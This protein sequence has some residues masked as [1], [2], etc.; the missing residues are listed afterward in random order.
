M[1]IT[2]IFG[3]VAV[4]WIAIGLALSLLMGR[5]GHQSCQWFVIGAVLGPLAFA[6]AISALRH[7]TGER[8]RL[9][10]PGVP[11]SGTTDIVVGVDGSA[12]ARA[13]VRGVIQLF[14]EAMGRLTLVTVIPYDATNATQRDAENILVQQGKDAA[15]RELETNILRGKPALELRRFATSGAYDVLAI[16]TRGAGR[17]RALLGS[18]ASELARGSSVPVLLFSV[19]TGREETR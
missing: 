15:N 5:Q 8:A 16:G 9:L 1:S 17:A 12:E 14:G 4:V 3:I 11:G 13:A 6:P 2:L 10:H 19:D 18:A 7:P